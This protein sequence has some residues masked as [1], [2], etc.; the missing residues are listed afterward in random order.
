VCQKMSGNF[1]AKPACRPFDQ[2][3]PQS[4]VFGLYTGLYDQG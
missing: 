4:T 3:L 1:S 2:L